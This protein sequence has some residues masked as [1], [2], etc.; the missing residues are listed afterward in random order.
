[1]LQ[2]IMGSR[3]G[4]VVRVLSPNR[5]HKCDSNPFKPIRSVAGFCLALRVFLWVLQ[6]Y[7][8]LKNQN[9]KVQFD[10]DREPA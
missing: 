10:Q 7:S 4:A 8:L 3:D 1:M 9:S 6:F 2:G 5:W